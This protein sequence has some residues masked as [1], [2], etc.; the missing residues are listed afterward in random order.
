MVSDIS[1]GKHSFKR[2]NLRTIS[3]CFLKPRN[4]TLLCKF[5]ILHK[6]SWNRT[7][8]SWKYL[9]A[10]K[11]IK[12]ELQT[13]RS[14]LGGGGRITKREEREK[15]KGEKEKNAAGRGRTWDRWMRGFSISRAILS[16]T[17]S[18]KWDGGRASERLVP[19][20]G[21]ACVARPHWR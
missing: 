6:L 2:L 21:E 16:L 19:V 13:V 17:I 7:I 9:I 5:E 14:V 10:A 20:V 15:K 12:E 18:R 11:L 4:V 8:C 1:L 3:E